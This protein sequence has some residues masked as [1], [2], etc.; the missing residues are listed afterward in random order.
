MLVKVAEGLLIIC[1]GTLLTQ[2]LLCKREEASK[3]AGKLS[4]VTRIVAL[5]VGHAGTGVTHTRT[6]LKK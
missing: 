6:C 4:G 1:I 5:T 3:G 2:P